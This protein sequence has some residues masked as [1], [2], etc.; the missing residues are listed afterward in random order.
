MQG[1]VMA[2]TSARLSAGPDCATPPQGVAPGRLAPRQ[3]ARII[4]AARALSLADPAPAD[5]KLRF[6][7]PLIAPR[8]VPRHVP[9]H[10]LAAFDARCRALT[11]GLCR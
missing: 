3:K 8:H 9:R 4:D 11:S 2:K 10:L 1:A 5:F 6:D 7:V